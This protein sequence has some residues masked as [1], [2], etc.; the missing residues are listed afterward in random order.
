MILAEDDQFKNVVS[1]FLWFYILA[2][3][4]HKPV[5]RFQRNTLVLHVG[6]IQLG[7]IFIHSLFIIKILY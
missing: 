6:F 1:T 3:L 5:V 4:L 2:E 7:L